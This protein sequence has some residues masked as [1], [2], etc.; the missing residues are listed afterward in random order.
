MSYHNSKNWPQRNGNKPT[1]EPKIN[2]TQD[3]QDDAGQTTIDQ[4]KTT[5]GA[6]AAISAWPC[7]VYVPLDSPL[8]ILAHWSSVGNWPSDMNPLLP[9]GA[10]LWNKAKFPFLQSSSSSIGFPV[11]SSQAPALPYCQ[12]PFLSLLG[13]CDCFPCIISNPF[14]IPSN[15]LSTCQPE[16]SLPHVSLITFS[17][18]MFKV[19]P[20]L[21]TV[22]GKKTWPVPLH[23][24]WEQR[25]W[26]K[27]FQTLC[28]KQWRISKYYVIW[29]HL[30]T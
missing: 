18:H 4:F 7:P 19:I 29:C 16:E 14:V 27:P 21:L 3:N 23:L 30:T 28:S 24:P 15:L 8:K 22:F 20:C 11:V 9:P 17:S 10:S 25:T 26:L 2:C 13:S 12:S 5:V 6:A 1:M